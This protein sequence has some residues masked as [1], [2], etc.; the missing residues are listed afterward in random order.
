MLGRRRGLNTVSREELVG[1]SE[2]SEIEG[3]IEIF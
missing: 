2:M 1:I 3:K